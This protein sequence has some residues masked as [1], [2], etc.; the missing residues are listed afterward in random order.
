MR[1]LSVIAVFIL[2]ACEHPL[3]TKEQPFI[4]LP[5]Y[6]EWYAE[7]EACTG[8]KGDFDVI[9]F[10]TAESITE[11]G[12]PRGGYWTPPHKITLQDNMVEPVFAWLIKHE[13]MHDLIQSG[14]H[15]ST[16]FKGVCGNLGI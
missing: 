8:I 5:V 13:L 4:P 1:A 6:R 11:G 16:Y 7:L 3:M 10:F 14:S 15:P 9:R 12:E 2:A